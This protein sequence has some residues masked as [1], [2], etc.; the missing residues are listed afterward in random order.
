MKRR[1]TIQYEGIKKKV[2]QSGLVQNLFQEIRV[3]KTKIPLLVI[4]SNNSNIQF[5]KFIFQN[6]MPFPFSS[7]N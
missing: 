6:E 2:T 3:Q 4:S 5:N 1:K 7:Y